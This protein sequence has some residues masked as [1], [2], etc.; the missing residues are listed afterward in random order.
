MLQSFVRDI[1]F[2]VNVNQQSNVLKL[3]KFNEMLNATKCS[4]AYIANLIGSPFLYNT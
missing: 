1:N 4:D 2:N 3:C